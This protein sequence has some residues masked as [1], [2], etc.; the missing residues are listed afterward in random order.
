VISFS[1]GVPIGGSAHLTLQQDGSYKFVG[2]FH[3]SSIVPFDYGVVLTVL[4]ID[5][6]LYTFGH[7]YS[8][9][10]GVADDNFPYVGNSAA[11][12]RN[13]LALVPGATWRWEANAN[14]DLGALIAAIEKAIQDAGPIVSAVI[15][16]VA[17]L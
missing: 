13:W 14:I 15:P 11:V 10:T 16:I 7:K 1:G 4:D 2:H 17:G 6:R 8:F 5:N 9:G 12:A 3:K